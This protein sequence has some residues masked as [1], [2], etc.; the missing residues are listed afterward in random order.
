M[1]AKRTPRLETLSSD[2]ECLAT[3][4]VVA[5]CL[6]CPTCHKWAAKDK[7]CDL[8]TSRFFGRISVH[9]PLGVLSSDIECLALR[10]VA[11]ACLFSGEADTRVS[12]GQPRD[13]HNARSRRLWKTYLQHLSFGATI[14][15]TQGCDP[16]AESSPE[17]MAAFG[18]PPGD[19]ATPSKKRRNSV[20]PLGSTS[21]A[22]KPAH[23]TRS[24]DEADPP[25]VRCNRHGRVG[26]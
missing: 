19:A 26:R 6:R 23:P 4:F 12:H 17:W 13:F 5:E 20:Q 18:P 16:S 10:F 22:L 1:E 25:P 3:R 14:R 8:K 24:A 11:A 15:A 21:V 2:I 7:P 9:P